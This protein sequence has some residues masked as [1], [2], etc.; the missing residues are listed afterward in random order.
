MMAAQFYLSSQS[1]LPQVLP[2][3]PH[4]D[5]LEHGVWFF[6]LGLLAFRAVREGEGWSAR[7]ASLFLVAGALAWGVSDEF[8]QSFV[9]GRAVEAAD[10]AADLAGA[11]VT[12]TVAERLLRRFGF[13]TVPR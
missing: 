10:V 12:G 9:P 1:R 11:A 8:H 5:K 3:L 7:G 13:L 4:V 2:A 6:V